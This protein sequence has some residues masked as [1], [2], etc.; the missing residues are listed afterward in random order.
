MV[1]TAVLAMGI[2][3]VYQALF[4]CLDAFTYYSNYVDISGWMDEKVWEAQDSLTRTA[5][6]GLMD[7]S[8][9]LAVQNREFSWSISSQAA[10]PAAGLY[11]VDLEVTWRSGK[12]QR[13]LT[14]TAFALYEKNEE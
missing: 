13:Q 10:D 6:L 12:K 9:T 2:V 8:G 14:R 11:Q 4:V 1:T 3:L 5:S 7:T